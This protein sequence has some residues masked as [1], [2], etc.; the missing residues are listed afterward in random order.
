MAEI[1]NPFDMEP[2][3]Q[4]VQE[5]MREMNAKHRGSPVATAFHLRVIGGEIGEATNAD[6][7]M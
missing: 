7:V 5:R 2:H 6:T 3:V 4:N 1:P